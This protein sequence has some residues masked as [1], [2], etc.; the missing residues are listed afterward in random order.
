MIVHTIL[1][2]ADQKISTEFYSGVLQIQPILNVPGMTEFQLT[3]G[4]ILGLMPEVGIKR[5]LGERLPDPV[6]GAGIPRVELYIRESDPESYFNRA[7]NLGAVELS[8]I[9]E[10]PWGGRAGYVMD[11][12]GHVLAFA[13]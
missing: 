6:K 7:K 11:S 3:D 13:T 2:V 12:D 9:L 10:R 8:P 1:Y 5:I 4:H